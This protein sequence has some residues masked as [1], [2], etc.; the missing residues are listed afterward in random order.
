M[1]KALGA[2]DNETE[3]ESEPPPAVDAASRQTATP[4]GVRIIHRR[5]YTVSWTDR[6]LDFVLSW[7]FLLYS[8]V[9]MVALLMLVVHAMENVRLKQ[10]T[11][12]ARR[13]RSA[14]GHASDKDA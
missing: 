10:R 7:D 4:P 13:Q 6:V 2:D 8:A 1:R 14:V 9:F 11:R 12:T 5:K 3:S